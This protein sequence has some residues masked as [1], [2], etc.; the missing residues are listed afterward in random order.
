MFEEGDVLETPAEILA[1]AYSA[2]EEDESGNMSCSKQSNDF[3]FLCSC[4][5]F[6]TPSV[7]T[8]NCA[9]VLWRRHGSVAR[10]H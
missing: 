2:L 5:T 3:C 1:P 7:H 9:Q 8:S 4:V 10:L 6:P